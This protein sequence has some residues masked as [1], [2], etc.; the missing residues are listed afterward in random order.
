MTRTVLGFIPPTFTSVGY[1]RFL[2]PF[3]HLGPAGFALRTL[4]ERTNY[5]R[6]QKGT[7]RFDPALL[8]GIS[9]ILFPQV[10]TLPKVE[11]LDGPA[12]LDALC[13]E[14]AS[15]GIPVVYSPDDD[16]WKIE[17]NNPF[18]RDVVEA[19]PLAGIVRDRSAAL[20]V[21]TPALGRALDNGT[22]PIHVLPN[23]VEPRRWSRRP[24]TSGEWRIGWVGGASHA[25]DLLMVLPAIVALRRRQAVRFIVQGL[26]AESL[27][28]SL[29]RLADIAARGDAAHREAFEPVREL[30]SKL[31]EMGAT[32]KPFCPPD[33]V[34]TA[35]PA[36]DLDIGICP[37]RGTPFDRGKSA[38]KS[39]EYAVSGSLSVAS[40]V[41]PY[42]GEVSVTVPNDAAAWADVLER[43]LR[44]RDEREAEL[45][46][47][48]SFVL[49]ERNIESL[50]PRW[51]AA[52]ES[53]LG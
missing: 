10:P 6:D 14:A 31:V 15:R 3:A 50:A 19:R 30:L 51:A 49:A 9:L 24:C 40:A 2:Q 21:T 33:Q 5:V 53:V 42:L 20:I 4:A 38:I 27:D 8:D 16:I 46:K 22:T 41:E 1:L 47:Q 17:R 32:H 18:Y 45:E 37:L 36:L 29:P 43:F 11:G 35:I 39:T 23:A 28:D 52:L 12:A 13:S 44:R 7:I 34:F 48:R 26:V 25:L